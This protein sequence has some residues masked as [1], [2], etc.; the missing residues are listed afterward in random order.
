LE[1]SGVYRSSSASKIPSP[2]LK[3]DDNVKNRFR[4][5]S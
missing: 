2:V 5:I 3:V 1:E 4:K